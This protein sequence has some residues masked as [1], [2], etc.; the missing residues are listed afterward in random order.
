MAL[1]LIKRY[2]STISCGEFMNDQ[3]DEQKRNHDLQMVKDFISENGFTVEDLGLFQKSQVEATEAPLLRPSDIEGVSNEPV[4]DAG[5]LTAELSE[6]KRRF[7]N[8]VAVLGHD[9]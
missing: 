1:S 9:I 3:N 2:V 8:L 7:N 5:C 4:K 6:L